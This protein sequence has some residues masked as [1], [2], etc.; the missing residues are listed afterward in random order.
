MILLDPSVEKHPVFGGSTSSIN[1]H[2]PSIY[3]YPSSQVVSMI[4]IS[5]E[6][7]ILSVPIS[8]TAL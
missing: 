6:P 8:L 4:S 2:A 7:I 3:S 5:I 1:S